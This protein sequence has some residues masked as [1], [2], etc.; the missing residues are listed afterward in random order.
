MPDLIS[1]P[2][3]LFVI[4]TVNVDETTYIG[5]CVPYTAAANLV[6]FP[7][8][9]L[10]AGMAD[11]LPMGVQIIAPPGADGLALRVAR[12]LEQAASEHRVQTPP[13]GD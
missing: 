6:G 11:G 9:A 4:G 10:P 1:F 13:L 7:S 8:V 3:N 12:A 5:R 2:D